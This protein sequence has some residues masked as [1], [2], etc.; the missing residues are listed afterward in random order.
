MHGGCALAAEA[1]RATR[2]S[3]DGT[4]VLLPTLGGDI[5]RAATERGVLVGASGAGAKI[6]VRWN[7]DDT[8]TRLSGINGRHPR[9]DK[10]YRS[11]AVSPSVVPRCHRSAPPGS[12]VRHSHTGPRRPTI[13]AV[14]I[15]PM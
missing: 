7:R 11:V 13:P 14:W 3:R 10:T 6:L 5:V 8:L 4:P 2:W 15:T 9:H 1:S 12:R